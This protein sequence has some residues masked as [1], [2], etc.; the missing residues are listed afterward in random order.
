MEN[1]RYLYFSLANMV[2]YMLYSECH[3][4]VSHLSI[5][6]I[7]TCRVFKEILDIDF[8]IS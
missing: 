7:N 6:I 8:L 4:F 2:I 5:K 1:W 3:D